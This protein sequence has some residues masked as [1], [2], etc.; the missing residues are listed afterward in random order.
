MHAFAFGGDQEQEA[1][2]A[3]LRR[4]DSGPA[5]LSFEEVVVLVKNL[6]GAERIAGLLS[7]TRRAPQTRAFGFVLSAA[8]QAA[9]GRWRGAVTSLRGADAL[10][11]AQFLVAM[12][13]FSTQPLLPLSRDDVV[14]TRSRLLAGLPRAGFGDSLF[15]DRHSYLKPYLLGLL[16]ARLEANSLSAY[17]A[18]L[19][20]RLADSLAQRLGRELRAITVHADG[21]AATALGHL[22][23]RDLQEWGLPLPFR[24]A[25]SPSGYER[26]LRAEWLR[27]LGRDDEALGWYA[28]LEQEDL[29]GLIYV[30]P[31]HL[32]QAEIYEQRGDLLKARIQYER[33]LEWWGNA[34]P[35]L[36]P[37]VRMASSRVATLSISVPDKEN[38]PD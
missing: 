29:Q 24:Y 35:E 9:Q 38:A 30:A 20:R 27:E 33:F 15:G 28:G 36:Q 12:A 23:L 4:L 26:F 6:T 25:F 16:D 10:D 11:P 13:F 34:D 2:L 22:R 31:G 5:I 21:D 18:A 19:E 32:R 37:L 17:T 1:V 7:E 3:E 14:G 8:L